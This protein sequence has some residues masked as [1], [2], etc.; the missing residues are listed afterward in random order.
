MHV[1]LVHSMQN[2]NLAPKTNILHLQNN[3]A[4]H[5]KLP[6][7][8]YFRVKYILHKHKPFSFTNAL[9]KGKVAVLIIMHFEQLVIFTRTYVGRVMG[10]LQCQ[11][12]MEQVG[13]NCLEDDSNSQ[14]G[15]LILRTWN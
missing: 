3:L 6:G 8:Y 5:V 1:I 9:A 4:K 10:N 13:P 15:K 7:S 12:S 14:W 11:Q 2:W